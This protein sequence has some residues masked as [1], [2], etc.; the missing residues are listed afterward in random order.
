MQ[1]NDLQGQKN[2]IWTQG[3]KMKAKVKLKLNQLK[4]LLIDCWTIL[5]NFI[6]IKPLGEL[7]SF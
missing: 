7:E 6:T 1:D 3:V 5:T 2:N 4:H